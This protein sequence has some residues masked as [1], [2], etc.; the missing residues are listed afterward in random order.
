MFP[1]ILKPKDKRTVPKA[2]SEAALKLISAL[3][4]AATDDNDRKMSSYKK[5]RL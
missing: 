2:V 5:G 4:N 3:E 1:S